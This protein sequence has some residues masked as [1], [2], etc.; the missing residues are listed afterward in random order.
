MDNLTFS[1]VLLLLISGVI[2]E[3]TLPPQQAFFAK[4]AV[5][6]HVE[7]SSSCT[8]GFIL[9]DGKSVLLCTLSE[10]I[11]IQQD[12]TNSRLSETPCKT[13]TELSSSSAV[14]LVG[15]KCDCELLL[16]D[17]R[18]MIST[19][20][21][22]FSFPI[23]QKQIESQIADYLFA[24][25]IKTNLRPLSVGCLLSSVDS[26]TLAAKL[27]RIT[28][29]GEVQYFDRCCSLDCHDGSPQREALD[30]IAEALKSFPFPTMNVDHIIELKLRSAAKNT[31]WKRVKEIKLLSLP[32]LHG[33]N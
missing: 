27:C 17:I 9:N 7:A 13:I 29:D 23:P 28:L 22:K 32:A 21:T 30:V 1:I 8:M 16:R 5:E 6:K 11:P 10:D 4:R 14:A 31:K 15:W 20:A 18:E 2:S 19:H 24:C 26:R 33:Q 3:L 12:L 25:C